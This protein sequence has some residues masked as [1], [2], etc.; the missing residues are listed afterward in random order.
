[1]T[2]DYWEHVHSV[3]PGCE[4]GEH[5]RDLH[6]STAAGGLRPGTDNGTYEATLFGDRAV[7]VIGNHTMQA[8]AGLPAQ[9]FFMYLA[10]HNE[11]D[12]HQ[13]PLDSLADS[14]VGH[15]QSDVYVQRRLCCAAHPH[16]PVAALPLAVRVD[17]TAP[18]LHAHQQ[19]QGDRS[20]DSY[21][22]CAGRP[23]A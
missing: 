17:A 23:G 16:C 21:D 8:T 14:A 20:V 3:A 10:F 4:L 15:I 5:S 11:H 2:A 18:R 22:G 9:P 13:A 6:D 19:V 7:H 1:M 12:P